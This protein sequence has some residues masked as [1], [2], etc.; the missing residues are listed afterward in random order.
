MSDLEQPQTLAQLPMT[1]PNTLEYWR[2]Q[3]TAARQTL[4]TLATA[5]NW[6]ANV[7]AYLGMGNRQKWGRNTTLVRK[8]ASLTDG[9]K[10]LLFF[11]TPDVTATA[12]NPQFT[13]AANLVG[14]V[15]NHYL[16]PA[17][18]NAEAMVD[19]VLFDVICPSGIGIS[20]LGY[21]AFVDPTIREVPMP[22]PM[23][24]AM[25]QLGPDGAPVMQP[26]IVRQTYFWKR[27]PPKMFLYPPTFIGSDYD[28]A[29]WLG[30]KYDLD[31]VVAERLYELQGD[32]VPAGAT[33][34]AFKDLLG[35]DVS[36][37][38]QN[39]DI[40]KKVAL[41]EIWYRACDIDPTIG[42]PEI[43]RQLVIM[44]GREDAP[45]IHR[46]SPY[47]VITNG[48][49]TGGMKGF[50]VHVLTLRYVSDQAI[51]PSD[52]SVSRDQVDE[53]SR[54]RTQMIDQRDRAIPVTLYDTSR[55]SDPA[56]IDKITKAEVQEMIAAPGGFDGQNPPIISVQ[57]GQYGRENFT[58]NDVINRDIGEAWALGN[59]QLGQD[60]DT[61][62]TATEL[63]LMQAA[64]ETRM[65]KERARVLKW[66]AK[67]CQKLLALLQLFAD[68]PQYVSIVG[69]EG[70]PALM[71]WDKTAIGGDYAI[72]LAPDSS[73]RIDAVSEKKRAV[74]VF[75]MLGNDPL[76]D[77]LELR[78][79]LVRKLGMDG[80]LV[81]QPMPKPPEKPNVSVSLKGEDLSPMLPQYVNVT[82]LLA[83]LG[84][85]VQPATPQPMP[86]QGQPVNPGGTAPVSPIGK[87][88]D[89]STS[90]MLPGGGMA[91]SPETIQ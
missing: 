11:Q 52:C 58:F 12:R 91:P 41:Y 23:N 31:K 24:P 72:T 82:T 26:N 33:I 81:R 7:E 38:A 79:W 4:Q 49:R 46:D 10:A 14:A 35:S 34:D 73:Q 2:N 22:S 51:P 25:P 67:G 43:I 16:S 9:K 56:I 63:S 3:I 69:Q 45:L 18:T 76:I 89:E 20:K 55:L 59:N 48:R 75:Q 47:Q 42:D 27:V 83:A 74:D 61:R 21:E 28:D 32:Q 44:E 13:E 30:F 1:E 19:E 66:F 78:K 8:D 62:R 60:T 6:D 65:D 64:T 39:Q 68:E 40:T 17:E 86:P 54:G 53:L 70:L 90:G 15:L 36:R 85:G 37:A 57:R 80:K 71:Q 88:F 87:R 50:P 29:S 77:G 84:I 5:R